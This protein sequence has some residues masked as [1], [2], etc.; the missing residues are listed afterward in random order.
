MKEKLLAIIRADTDEDIKVDLLE[1][2]MR[3][4]SQEYKT[5][6]CQR[7]V[8]ILSCMGLNGFADDVEGILPTDV[9]ERFVIDMKEK[10]KK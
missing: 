2:V 5:W 4:T 8:M 6:A 9:W 1:S 7:D 3:M 10:Y